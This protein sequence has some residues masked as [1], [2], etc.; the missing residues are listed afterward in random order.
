MKQ[1]VDDKK[2]GVKKPRWQ[3]AVFVTWA[4]KRGVQ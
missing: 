2:N 3:L 1:S 4:D